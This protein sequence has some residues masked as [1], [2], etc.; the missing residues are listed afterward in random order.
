METYAVVYT[1]DYLQ[2]GCERHS[3]EE[4]QGFDDER[5]SKMDGEQA[6]KFWKKYKQF[7]FRCIEL[8]P[9]EPTGHDEV[10]NNEIT[11]YAEVK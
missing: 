10:D 5:I 9:C 4:W 7:I 6:I 1:S 2:I 11:K 3:I 8:S